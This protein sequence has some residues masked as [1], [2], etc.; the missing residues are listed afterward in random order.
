MAFSCLCPVKVEWK[1]C[2]GYAY[3]TGCKIRGLV[4]EGEKT[5][6]KPCCLWVSLR[7]EIGSYA[8]LIEK[9]RT[10]QIVNERASLHRDAIIRRH[11]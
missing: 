8:H 5:Y 4:C 9:K 10:E 1:A 2:Y 11:K 3:V 6:Q 7:N